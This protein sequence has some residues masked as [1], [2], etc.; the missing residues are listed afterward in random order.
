MFGLR[1]IRVIGPSMQPTLRNGQ[2]WCASR[3]SI[4]PGH[5]IVFREPGRP[6]LLTVKRAVSRNPDGWWVEGDNQDSSRDSRHYGP[7]A[8]GEIVAILRFRV[9]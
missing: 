2:I 1:L 5:L 7:V 4:R 3:G 9:R 6:A 8:D